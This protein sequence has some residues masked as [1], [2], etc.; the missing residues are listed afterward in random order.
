MNL[1]TRRVDGSAVLL[2]LG[3]AAAA[4]LWLMELTNDPTDGFA[5]FALVFGAP[6]LIAVGLVLIAWR[7]QVATR[8]ARVG[9]VLTMVGALFP[10]LVGLVLATVG[11]GL[12]F[13]GVREQGRGLRVGLALLI[14]GVVGLLVRLESG[15]GLLLFLPVLVL[16]TVALAVAQTR[17]DV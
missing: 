6:L 4:L 12:F 17:I 5:S 7:E 11:V 15:D 9:A 3:A 8:R 2:M 14:V 1:R 10:D 16:G 13:A